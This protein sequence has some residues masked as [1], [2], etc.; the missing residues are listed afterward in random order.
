MTPFYWFPRVWLERVPTPLR[1]NYGLSVMG[2]GFSWLRFVKSW[3]WRVQ[4]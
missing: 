4:P 1:A 2:I 3:Y